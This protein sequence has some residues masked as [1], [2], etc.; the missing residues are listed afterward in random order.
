M[1]LL[2]RL[3]RAILFLLLLAVLAA[4][5]ILFYLKTTGWGY[6]RAVSPGEQALRDEMVRTAEGW[7]GAKESDGSHQPI[8]D[9]YNAQEVLAQG[10]EV[11]YTDNWCAT[12]ASTVALQCGNT[13][14]I[15]TECGCQRQ[16]ELWKSI[17]CWEENDDYVPLPG[18]YIYYDWDA[19]IGPGDSTG[20]ADHVGIVVGTCGPFLK[21]IEGNRKDSVSYRYTLIGDYRIRGYGLPDYESKA[22]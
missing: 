16:I 7:L 5:G 4:G 11:K 8:I 13:D 21:V 20:W 1:K 14:L 2:R 19:P 12:F 22:G 3:L 6:A 10:Y 18:D 17:G 15:P 9:L